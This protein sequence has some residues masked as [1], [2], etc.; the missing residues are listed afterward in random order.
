MTVEIEVIVAAD[1]SLSPSAAA[2][3]A[4]VLEGAAALLPVPA[5]GAV[6]VELV[7]TQRI[8]EL[9]LAYFGDGSPTDVITF[10]ADDEEA[11]VAPPAVGAGPAAASPV[12]EH[13]GDVAVCV[14]IAIEQAREQGHSTVREVAFLALHGVLHLLGYNDATAGERAS[15]LAL[16]ARMLTAAER[17]RGAL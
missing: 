16:Q 11:W 1:V 3:I 17:E 4:N 5:A 10:P 15:M 2:A 8:V 13:L 7:S 9:H 12:R 14:P 6:T